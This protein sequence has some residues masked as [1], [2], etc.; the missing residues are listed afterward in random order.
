M[1]RLYQD[2]GR[3]DIIRFLE[4]VDDPASR[5]NKKSLYQRLPRPK[6]GDF[7]GYPFLVLQDYSFTELGR[8]SNMNVSRYSFDFTVEIRGKEAGTKDSKPELEMADQLHS[9]LKGR[10]KLL[11]GNN[12]VSV[13]KISVDTSRQTGV[14]V[15]QEPVNIITFN[16]SSEVEVQNT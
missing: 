12:E 15:T 16:I 6:S 14:G 10:E 4:E 2:V 13:A 9:F 11:L 8:N 3:E 1:A 5:F 7:D